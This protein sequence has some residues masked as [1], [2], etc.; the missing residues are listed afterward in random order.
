MTNETL[1]SFGKRNFPAFGHR[2]FRL[3][4]VGQCV[5]LI[6]TWM[7]NIGQSWLVL[8]LTGS[9]MKLGLVTAIQF[10]PV[11]LF[12]IFAGPFVDR[13]P[14][15]KMLLFTQSM[16]MLLAFALAALT[17]FGLVRYW[18]VLVLALL[19]GFTNTLDIPTR[20]SFIIELVGRENLMNAVSLNATMFNLARIIGPAVAGIMIG[21]IGIAPCFVL[22]GLSFIAVI[23]ALT[24]IGTGSAPG[25][26][27]GKAQEKVGKQSATS[28]SA[29]SQEA[30]EDDPPEVSRRFELSALLRETGEGLRYIESKPGILWPLALL[31]SL[32]LFVLNFNV[33]IPVFARDIIR[34]DAAEYGFLM[35]AM[36]IGSLAGAVTLAVKSSS[37]PKIARLLAGA[38]GM[39]AFTLLIGLQRS[40]LLSCV[41]LAL[42]GFSTILCTT[43]ANALVQIRSEDGMRGRVMSVFSMV[44]GGVTPIGSLYAGALIEGAGPAICLVVSGIIGLV[45]AG[46]CSSAVYR[47]GGARKP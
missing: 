11:L 20:Q 7:Q 46:I 25:N 17:G 28:R 2:N 16:L 21:A 18:H 22:N 31:G 8:K 3:F 13:F 19:L 15:K 36:G 39:S 44:F 32:S 29:A 33:I 40:F 1:L 43:Q 23:I 5:S 27:A 45:T 34:G 6:G 26:A 14:K 37:G 42:T 4:W 24:R 10:L 38:F 9:P 12:S 47:S 41:L 35:T 30:G